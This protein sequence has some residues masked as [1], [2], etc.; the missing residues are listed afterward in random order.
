MKSTL[1]EQAEEDK[2][3]AS[4]EDANSKRKRKKVSSKGSG[5][6]RNYATLVYPDSAPEN[7]MEIVSE[8]HIPVLISPLHDKDVNPDGTLK[9]PHYHVLFMFESVKDWD[10]QVK[11]IF[12]SFGAVGREIVNSSRGYARYLCHLDNPEKYQYDHSLVKSFGGADYSAIV[13]L[14]TD[15]A[16]MIYDM[17]R[18]IDVNQIHSFAEFVNRVW[19]YNRDWY[20]LV[21]CRFSHLVIEYIKSI[22]WE[23]TEGYERKTSIVNP[24]TGEFFNVNPDTGEIVSAELS[25]ED[26]ESSAGRMEQ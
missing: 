17:L 2:A 11:P 14:P 6:T 18:F 19:Y 22:T 4:K 24:D 13:H 26:E 1:I 25:V 9:K 12:D 23:E 10:T 7:W 21:T 8:L 15:D 16:K 3:I 20:S 5:R